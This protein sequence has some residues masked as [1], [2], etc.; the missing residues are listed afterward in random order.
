[1]ERFEHVRIAW[2]DACPDNPNVRVN[3]F[4]QALERITLELRIS[5]GDQYPLCI[6][7]EF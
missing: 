2:A 5:I 4:D 1:V 6:G 3:D 7:M